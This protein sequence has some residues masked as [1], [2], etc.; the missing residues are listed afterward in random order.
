[1]DA[2]FLNLHFPFIIAGVFGDIS[3]CVNLRHLIQQVFAWLFPIQKDYSNWQNTHT[4]HFTL[5][6]WAL[7]FFFLKLCLSKFFTCAM[8]QVVEINSQLGNFC[9]KQW[10]SS[11]STPLQIYTLND[12]YSVL[13]P[14][15]NKAEVDKI[16]KIYK[17]KLSLIISRKEH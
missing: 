16:I 8:S 3:V 9:L 4:L 6:E 11:I 2:V 12:L 17:I 13:W 15:G 5:V 7:F 10:V 14:D 1:M